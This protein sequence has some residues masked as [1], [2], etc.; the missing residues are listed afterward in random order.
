MREESHNLRHH[1]V[2]SLADRSSN[3][4]NP[5]LRDKRRLGRARPAFT[6]TMPGVS[7]D[8]TAIWEMPGR[9]VAGACSP[10]LYY[11]QIRFEKIW[12]QQCRAAKTIKRRL[13]AKSALNYLIREKLAMFAKEAERSP[14]VAKELPRFL[15]AIWQVFNQYE[16][17]GYI[18]SRKSAAR[19]Q[20]R[21]LLYV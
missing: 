11:P 4:R 3:A 15:A 21:R 7:S 13:G 19:K 12:V 8:G 10:A 1:L 18:A 17:A 2:L 5:T 16:L 20:L 14:E 6:F 9:S